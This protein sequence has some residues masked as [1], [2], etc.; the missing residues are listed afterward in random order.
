ME[1]RWREE[2]EEE[3][4]GRWGGGDGQYWQNIKSRGK[5]FGLNKKRRGW[6]KNCGTTRFP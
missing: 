2:E 3:K 5:G 6:I 1:G 4:R